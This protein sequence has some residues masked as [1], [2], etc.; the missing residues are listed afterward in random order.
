MRRAKIVC[1][2]GPASSSREA[3]SRLISQGM[4]VARINFSHSSHD[5]AVKIITRIREEATKQTRPV[6]ILSDL[7]GP[8]IRVG[9]F[10]HSSVEL[11]PGD[12][13]TITT[14]TSVIGDNTRVSTDYT[15][16]PKDIT[17]GTRIL[18][19]DGFLELEALEIRETEIVTKVIY[20]GI[21]RNHK[22]INIP[23][24]IISVP[25]LSDKDKSDLQFSIKHH[26]DFIGLSFVRTAEDV[27]Q[28]KKLA[29]IGNIAIP[30]IAKIEL[31]EALTNLDE[32]IKESDGVMVARGDLGVEFG[33]EKVPLFQK[34]IIKMAN[35][36]GKLVI[37]ATQM[38][39]SMMT[40]S[41]PT[42]AEVSDVANAVLD[43]TD[44]V[45]LSGE[46][47]A[48][49]YPFKALQIMNKI[50]CE[51]EQSEHYQH[52]I[53]EPILDI[54]IFTNA[55]AH[56]TAVAVKRMHLPIIVTISESGGSPRLLSKYRP[57]VPIIALTSNPV[58]Y[59]RLASY[60]GVTPFV[61]PSVS[62]TKQAIACVRNILHTNNLITNND[63]FALTLT[64]PMQSGR[65]INTLKILKGDVNDNQ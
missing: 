1:T 50:I 29:M 54:P 42:R 18:L 61:I 46:T 26:V 19:D 4:D 48:G 17:Q 39:E 30:V 44:A 53:G 63:Y 12:L 6:A 41:R 16:L 62:S 2:I 8:K 34:K 24:A 60:W 27:R 7:Q 35:K 9:I 15:N 51:I 25:I 45:M 64:S 28:T 10:E 11:I 21:L 38:L 47:A 33:A 56:A 37:T 32:I 43:G 22:G 52:E 55:I 36:L 57:E 49:K 5:D 13:F 65:S 14:D 58:I 59:T 31:P 40:N 20:G 23:D 3:I